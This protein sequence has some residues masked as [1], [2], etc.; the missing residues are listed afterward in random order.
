M[1]AK[2]T[3]S[4]G[5][6]NFIRVGRAKGTCTSMPM[7]PYLFA[8]LLCRA[9]DSLLSMKGELAK[10]CVK[11]MEAAFCKCGKSTNACLKGSESASLSKKGAEGRRSACAERASRHA[12]QE[13]AASICKRRS[14]PSAPPPS[15]ER[16]L[17]VQ[18]APEGAAWA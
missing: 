14:T 11:L 8:D 15:A 5:G 2:A 3:P 16:H 4:G 1:E 9:W 7:R 13:P 10:S 18:T 12:Q 6:G 17:S